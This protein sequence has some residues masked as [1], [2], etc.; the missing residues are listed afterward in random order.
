VTANEAGFIENSKGTDGVL[1]V[2]DGTH[3]ASI[4]LVGDYATSPFV[5]SSD[6]HGG[7]IVTDPMPPN[8]TSHSLIAAMATIG[9][10]AASI[11]HA[12][13][14]PSLFG[15][16]PVHA[17]RICASLRRAAAVMMT[18]KWPP[19]GNATSAL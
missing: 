8:P 13:T 2:S 12:D 14:R 3:V 10:P 18:A 11:T 17:G 6:G 19:I 9:A 1:T 15:S 5:A 7:T 16:P 4:H